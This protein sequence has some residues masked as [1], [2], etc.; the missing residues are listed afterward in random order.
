VAA[1]ASLAVAWVHDQ[2]GDAAA[3]LALVEERRDLPAGHSDDLAANLGDQHRIGGGVGQGRDPRAELA[4]RLRVAQLDQSPG[5]HRCVGG[6]GGA[7]LHWRSGPGEGGPAA[8]GAAHAATCPVVLDRSASTP[9]SNRRRRLWD[10]SSRK[11]RRAHILAA[12]HNFGL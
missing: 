12:V 10:L 2:R 1:D 11:V 3:A 9:L 7:D 5:Q 8:A 6:V 4:G